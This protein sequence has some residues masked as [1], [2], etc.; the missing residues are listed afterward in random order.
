[1]SN[2]PSVKS[3]PIKRKLRHQLVDDIAK[4]AEEGEEAAAPTKATK[5]EDNYKTFDEPLDSRS[6]DNTGEQLQ[7]K[8]YWVGRLRCAVCFELPRSGPIFGCRNGH[9]VCQSCLPKLKRCAICR[10]TD[11]KCR[12]LMVEDVL[13]SVVKDANVKCKHIHCDV[14]GRLEH[15]TEHEN[16]CFYREIPCPM[17]SPTVGG[18]GGGGVREGCTFKG[19]MKEFLFH[20]KTAK[21][22]H[23]ISFTES[24]MDDGEDPFEKETVFESH[25]ADTKSGGTVLGQRGVETVW[26]PTFFLSKKIINAGLVCLLISR[27]GDGMWKL[28]AQALVPR[29]TANYWTVTIIVTDFGRDDAPKFIFKGHPVSNE[30]SAKEAFETG[31]VMILSDEQIRPFKKPNTKHLFQYRIKFD[32]NPNFEAKC[33]NLV[34]GHFTLKEQTEGIFEES[35]KSSFG[36]ASSTL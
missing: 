35:E 9:H 3:K 6:N 34:N 30:L 15:V 31:Q 33:Q 16:I 22:C 10:E 14:E 7:I 23:R 27:Q 5:L 28:I 20:I 19:P 18:G 26:K 17:S 36:P 1:M 29:E 2:T 11:L 24:D 4:R 12:Q 32:L 25:V 13:K 8:K 21:C